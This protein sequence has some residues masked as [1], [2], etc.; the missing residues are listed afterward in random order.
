MT[1]PRK[2]CRPCLQQ[3]GCLLLVAGLKIRECRWTFFKKSFSEVLVN[4]SPNK[5]RTNQ[6]FVTERK[7]Q[8]QWQKVM[9]PSTQRV[10]NGTIV[11]IDL[12]RFRLAGTTTAQITAGATENTNTTRKGAN[13]RKAKQP[14][15]SK[16]S[17]INA[18]NIHLATRKLRTEPAVRSFWFGSM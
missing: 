1:A 10:E 13:T 9:L 16:K 5:R 3:A 18:G 14:E 17:P 6:S 2:R 15:N 8:T 12:T 11:T 4:E 7:V